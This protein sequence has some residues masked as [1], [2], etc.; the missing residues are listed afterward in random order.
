MSNEVKVINTMHI[1]GSLI[2]GLT[3]QICFL[4]VVLC[5]ASISS[6]LYFKSLFTRSFMAAS[7]GLA[8]NED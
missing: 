2:V 5:K 4:A 1:I 3:T 8:A 6:L 7:K